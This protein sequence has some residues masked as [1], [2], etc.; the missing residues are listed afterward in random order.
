M[1]DLHP[2]PACHGD[3]G[4]DFRDM[5][6]PLERLARVFGLPYVPLGIMPCGFCEGLGEI[7]E[8]ELRD[9]EAVAR[10][11]ADQFQAAVR[12]GEVVLP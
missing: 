8:D 5:D 2:C 11:T 1:P 7:T 4:H 6:A 3:G 10:A 12:A 9:A